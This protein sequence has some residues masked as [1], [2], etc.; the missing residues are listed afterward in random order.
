ME[1]S[2]DDDTLE[3]F[4]TI[5]V[6][7]LPAIMM[8]IPSCIALLSTISSDRYRSF[9]FIRE[10]DVSM[11]S[12][13]KTSP[14]TERNLSRRSS[15]RHDLGMSVQKEKKKR[16]TSSRMHP[17]KQAKP[18]QPSSQQD[19]PKQPS[20]TKIQTW[21]IFEVLV[22]PDA[23]VDLEEDTP[24]LDNKHNNTI[25]YDKM[26]LHPAVID[27][28][29]KR[30]KCPIQMDTLVEEN[31]SRSIMPDSWKQYF[32]DIRVVRRSLDAR[33]K[34]G[35][36]SSINNSTNNNLLDM[37]GPRYVYVLDMDI[38]PNMAQQLRLKDTP[39][40]MEKIPSPNKD[41]AL[42]QDKVSTI[43][44]PGQNKPQVII[45]GAGPAGL[46]CALTLARTGTVHVI[47]LER[48]QAVESRGKSIGALIHRRQL[49]TESNF[50]FGEGGAGTWSD[51]KLTT[52]IGRNSEA[53]RK[54]LETLVHFGAPEKILV[55]G[56]PHLGTDNLVRLLRNMRN[57]LRDLGA[58]VRFGARM[59]NL[60]VD[61]ENRHV[62]G[63]QVQYG[64]SMERGV[65]GVAVENTKDQGRS[66]CILADRVVI[67]TG[68]SARDVYEIL[69]NCGV[70]LEPKGFAV[71]FRVEHPQK[72]I[73]KIQYGEEWGASA[74]SGKVAT[75]ALNRDYFTS[76]LGHKGRLPV[77]SY[78]LATDKAFDGENY[79]GVFS[80]CQCP[81]KI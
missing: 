39:G 18:V 7:T 69:H 27:S 77:S 41:K 55:D 43:Q 25:P 46:F 12:W 81:G 51:V 60:I 10:K 68:H 37:E 78:R 17:T 61:S 15:H 22:H 73:N 42:L 29:L 28:L 59:T 75:D 52:R 32:I 2:H 50:A 44:S 4:F 40:R 49:C 80:F 36:N 56:A 21:R 79:R 47:L 38:T 67:A 76:A 26:Y 20:D 30:L 11:G 1:R 8:M 5:M 74:F 34:R 57:E 9:R 13:Y 58:V 48:G 66:E 14:W 64:K 70:H 16:P 33:R 63:V 62:K 72:L 6:R 19:R 24:T 31:T 71:G 45:V 3:L 53:V 35:R 65:G 54:V 23:L